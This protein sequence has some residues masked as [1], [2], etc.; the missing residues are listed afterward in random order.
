MKCV[1][2][3]KHHLYT[4]PVYIRPR[5]YRVDQVAQ[6]SHGGDGGGL[7]WVESRLVSCIWGDA[8]DG[9]V[10]RGSASSG[11]GD[12]GHS[13]L[14]TAVV[15][16]DNALMTGALAGSSDAKGVWYDKRHAQGELGRKTS[17]DPKRTRHRERASLS[18]CR[19]S[20]MTHP[21][22]AL[23]KRRTPTKQ[24]FFVCVLELGVCATL[25]LLLRLLLAQGNELRLPRVLMHIFPRTTDT[26]KATDDDLLPPSYAL[27]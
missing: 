1:S 27:R 6:S 11:V 26:S 2:R 3:A 4:P 12:G 14:A 16:A 13:R 18:T 21:S 7:G 10:R 5:T 22:R 23:F 19:E 24:C 17:Q 15:A 8:G 9:K 20:S 25:A